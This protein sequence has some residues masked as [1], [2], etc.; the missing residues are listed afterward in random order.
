MQYDGTIRAP[1]PWLFRTAFR[2][3][4]REMK[5]ERR[6][7]AAMKATVQEPEKQVELMDALRAVPPAQRA[8]LFLHYFAD[9]PIT[10]IARRQG[11]TTAAI[12]VRLMRGRRVLRG[13]LDEEGG[14]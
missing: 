1:V 10:E 6:T 9:L 14:T 13:L 7:M 5:Q 3:A 11:T 2:I 8:A 4:S 12:K